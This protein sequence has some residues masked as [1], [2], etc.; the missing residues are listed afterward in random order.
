[1]NNSTKTYSESR[2]VP[3]VNWWDKLEEAK[4]R[5][6]TD[7]EHRELKNL[8]GSW[9]TCACGN[10]CDALPRYIDELK[11]GMPT[12]KLLACLGSDFFYAIFEQD[13]LS[14]E[15]TLTQIEQRSSYLLSLQNKT[16]L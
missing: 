8:A 11:N 1:M 13:W 5:G 9:V 16:N 14:A 6:V 10:Q 7:D 2:G 15:D 12:D 3:K 4:R